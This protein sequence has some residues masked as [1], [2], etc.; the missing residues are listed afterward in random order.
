MD[1]H[2]IRQVELLKYSLV[3]RF[4]NDMPAFFFFR[5]INTLASE[6]DLIGM[7]EQH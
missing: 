4:Q 2:L 3:F 6:V 5:V 1:R 7:L